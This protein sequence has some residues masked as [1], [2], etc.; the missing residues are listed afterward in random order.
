MDPQSDAPSDNYLSAGEVYGAVRG[1][2][3][4]LNQATAAFEHAALTPLFLLNG[5]ATVAFLT[6]LGAASGKARSST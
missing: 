5:G 1:H 6:L 4:M 2:E 3:L